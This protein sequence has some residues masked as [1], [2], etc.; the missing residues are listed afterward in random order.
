METKS[1]RSRKPVRATAA[2]LGGAL[3]AALIEVVRRRAAR[4]A[5]RHP[6]ET[7]QA[8]GPDEPAPP[9]E[10]APPAEHAPSEPPGPPVD[11]ETPH[12]R[13]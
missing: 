1:P 5:E 4:T 6:V 11:P 8:S 9:T 2:A 3:L 13:A 10:H 12:H 7:P